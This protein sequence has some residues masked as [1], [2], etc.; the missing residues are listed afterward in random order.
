[1]FFKKRGLVP[2]RKTKMKNEIVYA[3]RKK[4]LIVG[5]LSAKSDQCTTTCYHLCIK[6]D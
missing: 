3:E 2:S 6:E 1:M 5:A 4:K